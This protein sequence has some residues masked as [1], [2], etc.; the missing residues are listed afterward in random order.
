MYDSGSDNDNYATLC[1]VAILLISYLI[2]FVHVSA[3]IATFLTK[4]VRYFLQWKHREFIAL[5]RHVKMYV[6][7]Y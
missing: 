2:H 6:M 3:G 5:H 1:L 4:I 7:L